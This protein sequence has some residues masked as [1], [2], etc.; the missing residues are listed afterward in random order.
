MPEDYIKGKG[1][2]VGE[3]DEDEIRAGIDEMDTGAKMKETGLSYTNTEPV[4]KDGRLVAM[5]IYVC[6]VEDFGVK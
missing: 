2:F 5:K 1:I 4:K 3:Y 6:T